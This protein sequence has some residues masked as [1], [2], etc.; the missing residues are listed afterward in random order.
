MVFFK[1]VVMLPLLVKVVISYLTGH[2]M[3]Q[4]R[5]ECVVPSGAVVRPHHSR[6]HFISSVSVASRWEYG[7]FIHPS[8][9]HFSTCI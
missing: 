4:V 3:R 6:S 7:H 2:F 8:V 5:V 9:I 1:V